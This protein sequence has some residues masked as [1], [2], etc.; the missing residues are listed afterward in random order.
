[1]GQEFDPVYRHARFRTL[2]DT[3][4]LVGDAG[5]RLVRAAST[6]FWKPGEPAWS[7]PHAEPEIV[8]EAGFA[9]LFFEK[10][11]CSPQLT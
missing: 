4:D 11:G 3:I 2:A 6:L 5:F 1:M 8:R 7:H 10:V 9:G